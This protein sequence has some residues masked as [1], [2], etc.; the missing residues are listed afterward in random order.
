MGV[1][2]REKPRN[3][4][5][6]YIFIEH[7]GKRKAKKIGR[8]K[9]LALQ[10]AKQ[11]EAKLVL[12]DTGLL[13]E[14]SEVPTFGDVANIWLKTYIKLLRRQ[15]TYERYKGVL[16]THVFPTIKNKD[17]D[18]IKRGDI[19]N[20][21]L[22]KKRNYSTS[23]VCIIRDVIS[24]VFNHAVDDEIILA[25][26]IAG[27]TRR[28]NLEKDKKEVIPFRLEEAIDFLNTAEASSKD[29]YPLFILAFRTGLRMGE[30]IGLKWSDVDFRSRF[31]VVKRSFKNGEYT[32]PK[33]G[34]SR[35]VDL[36]DQCLS[37][38]K[39]L[40]KKRNKEALSTGKGKTVE[41]IFHREGVPV[42]QNTLRGIFKRILKKAGI[43]DMR[44]HDIRHTYAS[45][46]LS[47]GQSPQ[48]VKEQMGHHS[49]QV[50]VDIY[51]HMIPSSNRDAVNMLDIMTQQ[52]ATYPQPQKEKEPQPVKVTA[53]SI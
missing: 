20:L 40:R 11:I 26:P 14:K 53:L 28:L 51:G 17:I 41:T 33:N 34:K 15:S 10:V 32:R 38:L 3:S 43:R 36:S 48:Y 8:D 4:G 30:L 21:L 18:S 31:L 39:K 45:M 27:I 13:E 49:I 12:K 6:W 29:F 24:G 7:H 5:N 52:N 16:N 35:R 2:V 9:K 19:R 22:S 1:R 42:A 23:T 25:N 37:E 47:N 46:L 50:T 44:F